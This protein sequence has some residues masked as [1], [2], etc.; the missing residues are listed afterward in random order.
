MDLRAGTFDEDNFAEL[1][2]TIHGENEEAPPVAAAPIQPNHQAAADI[3]GNPDKHVTKVMEDIL[4]LFRESKSDAGH[5]LN[6][7]GF[8]HRYIMN[9]NPKEKAAIEAAFAELEK[10]GIVELKEGHPFLTQAG[11]DYIY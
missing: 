4:E 2:A 10:Q 7:R 6:M 11:V 8:M 9:Y 3:S 5:A 1:T